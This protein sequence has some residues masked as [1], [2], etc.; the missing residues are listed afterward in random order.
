MTRSPGLSR[1]SPRTPDVV[2]VGA[3]VAGL[4]AAARLTEAGVA[5]TVLEARDR[6]GGRVF[7]TRDARME[8]PI[9][10]GAEFLHGAAERTSRVVGAA[11]RTVLD[12][13]GE[14]WESG[15]R[16]LRPL[17]DFWKRLDR[18]M[19]RLEDG[20]DPDRS[21]ADFLARRPGG[22][23]LAGERRLAEQFV[24]GFHAANPAR[25]SERALAEGGSPEG[26]PEEQRMARLAGGY[27][28][29]PELLAAGLA[30]PPRLGAVVTGI[31]W[32]G[33]RALVTWREGG[34]NHEARASQV[35]VT[36]P[37][38]VLEAA[39]GAEGA[40]EF[41][42]PL[43]PRWRARLAQLPMGHVIRATVVLRAPVRELKPA[44]M[45][46]AP[47]RL[48][49]LTFLHADDGAMPVCWTLYPADL[50]A[51]IVWFGGPEAEA[52][53]GMGGLEEVIVASLAARLH[54]PQ[55]R[56]ADAVTAVHL[57]DWGADPYARGA[58][59]YVA[60]GGTGAAKVLAR[61]LAPTLLFA[62]EAFAPGG[63]NGTVEGAIAS[64]ESAAD[65]VLR[66]RRAAG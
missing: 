42:P 26:D 19:R 44:G 39:P 35:I 14:R 22:A 24:R 43:P 15:A 8:H 65:R 25:A 49:R 23:S 13:R 4:A 64:G 29:L 33:D 52:L 1:S 61:P 21:F 20:R 55:R 63:Q 5:V 66:A 30:S 3:G 62:G 54:L 50:P 53:S 56:L 6:I 12:I 9:E 11:G 17:P 41:D 59:S 27:A 36:V 48:R 51:M 38:G 34:A 58:Y 45:R 16:G 46:D 10:L 60:V 2:I 37:V 18:V 31:R 28:Q 32:R 47:E 57:H 7:T 40:I